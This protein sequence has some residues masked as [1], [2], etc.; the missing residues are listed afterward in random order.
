LRSS[1]YN[2]RRRSSGS[3]R[4]AGGQQWPRIAGSNL[5]SS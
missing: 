1:L 4:P 2:S 3:M 5:P